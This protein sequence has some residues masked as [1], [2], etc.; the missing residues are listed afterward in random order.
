ML[1]GLGNSGEQHWQSLWEKKYPEIK[2]VHQR[3]WDIPVCDEWIDVIDAEVNKHPLKQV[4]LIGHSLACAT[5]S[6]WAQKYNRKI[7]GAL[8]VAPSDTEAPT[9][10][11]G[12]TGFAPVPLNKL[13]F[14]S[15]VVAST[16]DYYITI[17]RA[18]HFA[19]SWG[20]K[21]INIG[22]AGHINVLSGF[23]EWSAGLEILQ[24]LDASS[25]VF[26]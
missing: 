3:E 16:N 7:K 24:S 8:I 5:I 4:I 11:K 2:R 22:D 19:N 26:N 6:F 13:P 20:S 12:T 1:P 17:E 14:P 10:P 25:Q 23:G 21:L 15:I 18:T 9:Y